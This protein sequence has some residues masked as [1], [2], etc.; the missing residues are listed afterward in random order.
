MINIFSIDGV[1]CNHK[2]VA[3]PTGYLKM[4]FDFL[5]TIHFVA[6]K[7]DGWLRRHTITAKINVNFLHKSGN[8]VLASNGYDDELLQ[9]LKKINKYFVKFDKYMIVTS[10]SKDQS[11]SDMINTYDEL[12]YKT[13]DCTKNVLRD[14]RE[15]E[16][17]FVYK[18]IVLEQYE[19]FG[20][21]MKEGFQ[22][23]N[24]NSPKYIHPYHHFR[25]LKN[26]VSNSE[27]Y[28]YLPKLR[29]KTKKI[30]T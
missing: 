17:S 29:S 15:I 23:Y 3:V 2:E 24:K 9:Q 28:T 6:Y 18:P 14:F 30:A 27:H 8:I 1:P 26:F 11:V 5:P 4:H 13:F 21:D 20:L 25:D 10:T 7:Y 19:K 16:K 22:I 12:G